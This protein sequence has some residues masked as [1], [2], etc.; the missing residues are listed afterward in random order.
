[1]CTN[2]N[3]KPT[4]D[5]QYYTHNVN[6]HK[7]DLLNLRLR[8]LR[9]KER[10]ILSTT[11]PRLNAWDEGLPLSARSVRHSEGEAMVDGRDIILYPPFPE[12]A[13]R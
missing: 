3:Q 8:I 7:C 9:G 5:K 4:T 11:S 6:L 2:G 10:T 13:K 12:V 1:M